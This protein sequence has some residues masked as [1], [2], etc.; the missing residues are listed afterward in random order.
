MIDVFWHLNP[1]KKLQKIIKERQKILDNAVLRYMSP[2]VPF[3][4]G[5]LDKSAT[6]HT[7]IG[8][9]LII[10]STPYARYLY[11]GK[12]ATPSIPIKSGD[13]II[14]FFSPPGQ[15]KTITNKR[16]KYD[17]SKHPLATSHWFAKMVKDHKKD[18][19]REVGI[20]K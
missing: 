14:G 3:R 18:L 20:E 19:K 5:V 4:T 13:Q 6:I 16:L 17:K 11:Y 10:Q 15:P 8:S 12:K 1:D 2:Y 9:G 7:K